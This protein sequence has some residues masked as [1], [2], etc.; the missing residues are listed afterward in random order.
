MLELMER[1]GGGLEMHR[2]RKEALR[3]AFGRIGV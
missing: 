2:T 3:E 1:Y